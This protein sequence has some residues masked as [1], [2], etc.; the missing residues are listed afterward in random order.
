MRSWPRRCRGFRRQRSSAGL[1]E[2]L[3]I[4]RALRRIR[5]WALC[6]KLP[7][8]A[9]FSRAF[10]EFAPGRLA[11]RSN[12]RLKDEFGASSIRVKGAVK[13]MSPLRFGVP[14]HS[15]KNTAWRIAFDHFVAA[16]P[17]A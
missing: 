11:E 10:E 15:L 13:G 7:S 8:E 2:R 17:D 9:A 1:I 4:E 5:G 12:A 16:A 3:T 6:G 14:G